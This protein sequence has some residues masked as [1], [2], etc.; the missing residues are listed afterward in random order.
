MACV[1]V[2]TFQAAAGAAAAASS[3]GGSLN[4]R[5]KLQLLLPLLLLLPHQ[6]MDP[7]LTSCQLPVAKL[8]QLLTL[9]ALLLLLPYQLMDPPMTP[10]DAFLPACRSAITLR[11]RSAAPT[12]NNALNSSSSSSSSRG[13]SKS[14]VYVAADLKYQHQ[15]QLMSI[16]TSVHGNTAST[17]LLQHQYAGKMHMSA[18]AEY[19]AQTLPVPPADAQ[20]VSVRAQHM[21]ICCSC[22]QHL[23]CA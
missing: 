13:S 22:C 17:L 2:A 16:D 6:L 10:T 18:S 11:S 4:A 8:L 21:L 9:L 1:K 19:T 5:I 15:Q 3:C 20:A 14:C 23:A 12:F 7:L